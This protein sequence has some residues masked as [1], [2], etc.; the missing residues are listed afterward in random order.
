ML[1]RL[2]IL[3][4]I[5]ATTANSIGAV[6]SQV[7]ERCVMSCC[8]T[9]QRANRDVTPARLRCMVDCGQPASTSPTPSTALTA[10]SQK[11]TQFNE[12]PSIGLHRLTYAEQAR[13]PKSPTRS[14]D[15]NSA[16]YLETG[17]LLI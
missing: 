12:S 2:F 1:K 7:G 13:F 8:S 14:I 3:A 5:A 16:R 10:A 17:T 9:A 15:G 11:K 4:F 6:S